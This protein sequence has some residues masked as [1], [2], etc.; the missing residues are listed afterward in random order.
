M[1]YFGLCFPKNGLQ[2]TEEKVRAIKD[3]PIPQNLSE[4][5]SFL[6]MLAALTNF[7]PKL[8]TLAHPLCELRSN[9]E[10]GAELRLGFL[11]C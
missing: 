4:L 8:P 11:G 9:N 10:M 5:R 3:A 7:I 1:V 6:R 2:P